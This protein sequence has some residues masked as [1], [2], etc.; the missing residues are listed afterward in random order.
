MW[1]ER[2]WCISKN[3]NTYVI[4]PRTWPEP[5]IVLKNDHLAKWG[6]PY[7]LLEGHQRLA[8]FRKIYRKEQDTLQKNHDLWIVTLSQ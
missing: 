6:K 1:L 2:K 5:I 7:H 4:N 3:A 8:Y